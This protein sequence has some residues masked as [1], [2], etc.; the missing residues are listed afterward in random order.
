MNNKDDNIYNRNIYEN[1][2]NKEES[3]ENIK[4]DIN[5]NYSKDN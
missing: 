2:I 5:L 1:E 3:K 4:N